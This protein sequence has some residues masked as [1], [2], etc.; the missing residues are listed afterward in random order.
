M[1]VWTSRIITMNTTP[2]EFDGQGPPPDPRPGF[3]TEVLQLVAILIA[4]LPPGTAELHVS[5][6]PGHPEW[7][8][9]YFEVL[10]TNPRSAAIRGIASSGDLYLTIGEVEREFVGFDTGE[11]IASG[12][13]WQEELRAIWN[14]VTQ[15]G[16]PQRQSL[17][18]DG[19]VLGGASRFLIDGRE[20][21]F[22]GGKRAKTLFSK[23][24]YK[25][26]VYE[27]YLA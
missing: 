2:N 3:E 15:G 21:D 9:P 18:V 11:N 17:G 12:A 8:R 20:W 5:R 22:R 23:P 10:P 25:T 27:P 4:D 14:V 1:V 26:V 13:T 24:R 19:E 6:V 7:P 16:F